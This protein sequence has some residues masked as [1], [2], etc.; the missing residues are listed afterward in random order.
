MRK[1]KPPPLPVVWLP[2][3]AVDVQ[4]IDSLD[5]T[6]FAA[7]RRKATAA[8]PRPSATSLARGLLKL[9]DLP[10]GRVAI[11][12]KEARKARRSEQAVAES[13]NSYLR[14]GLAHLGEMTIDEQARELVRLLNNAVPHL[15]GEDVARTKPQPQLTEMRGRP[16]RGGL[17]SLGRRRS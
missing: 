9:T 6:R 5:G 13:V 14:L 17:P 4:V 10:D 2:V 11:W 8:G 7:A 15:T 16:V 1:P 12:A 3:A